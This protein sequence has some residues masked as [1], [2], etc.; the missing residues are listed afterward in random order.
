LDENPSLTSRLQQP[1]DKMFLATSTYNTSLRNMLEKDEVTANLDVFFNQATQTIDNVFHLF[2]LVAPSL[3]GLLTE[4]IADY[5]LIRTLTLTVMLLVLLGII[6]IFISFYLSV[7]QSITELR[8][9]IEQLAT[10]DLTT[11][12]KLATCDETH[13]IAQQANAMTQQFREL[14]NKAWLLTLSATLVC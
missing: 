8:K 6:Y 14:V 13:L 1:A 10:G 3:D 2:D 5:K 4:R 7:M 12:I 9:G 11:H